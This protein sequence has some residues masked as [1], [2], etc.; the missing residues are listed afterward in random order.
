[1]DRML[2]PLRR[3]REFLRAGKPPKAE[4]PA[5]LQTGVWGEDQAARWLAEHGFKIL[6]R[7]IRVGD[8]DEFDLVVRDG[9]ALVFV[10]V[11]T[12][13]SELFGTPGSAVDKAKRHSLSRAAV[14]YLRTLKHP[15]VNFRFDVVEVIG[16][17]TGPA[18]IVRHIPNAF[19]LDHCYQLPT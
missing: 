10:E 7:R 13:R 9:E 18:P 2:H 6:G 12:R 17:R 4:S 5:H 16:A 15:M 1:M 14:R 3:L 11:K 8:R 19:P